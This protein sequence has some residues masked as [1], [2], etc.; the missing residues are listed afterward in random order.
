MR[1]LVEEEQFFIRNFSYW[2]RD[3]SFEPYPID[4]GGRT[5]IQVETSVFSDTTYFLTAVSVPVASE[6]LLLQG[7]VPKRE[8]QVASYIQQMR[9]GALRSNLALTCSAI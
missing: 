4:A 8:T 7:K 1:S 2:T 5:P 6:Q 3:A 9:A